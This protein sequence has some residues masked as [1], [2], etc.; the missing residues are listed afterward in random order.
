MKRYEDLAEHVASLI[1]NGSLRAG[2]R[3]PSLR[4]LRRE[5]GVSPATVTH[6]YQLLEA[7]GLIETR[8][9]SGHYVSARLAPR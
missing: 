4:E 5:R 2:D 3:L 1:A 7:R 8:P 6:A 9:Q